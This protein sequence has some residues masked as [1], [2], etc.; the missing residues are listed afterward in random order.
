[1]KNIVIVGAGLSGSSM[2]RLLAEECGC[3]VIILEKRTHIAGNIYDEY[4]NGILVQKYGPHFIATFSWEVVEFLMKYTGF[5]EYPIRAKS[6]VNGKFIDRPYNFRT[7]QQLLDPENSA[8]VLE[9]IRKAFPN[10]HRVTL[11]EIV[12]NTD[13]VVSNYGKLLYN[14]LFVPYCAKQWGMKVEDISPDVINRTDIVLGYETQL[15][16]TDFQYLPEKGYTEMIKRMLDYPNIKV[17]LNVDA[18]EHL[19]FD[20]VNHKVLYN[21]SEDEII[22]YTGELDLLFHNCYGE[23]PY[24][25]RYFSYSTYE[26]SPVLPCGVITYPKEREY[27]RQTEFKQFNPSGEW[28]GSIVQSE[29]SLPMNRA[30]QKGNE[31]YYPVLNDKNMDQHNKYKQLAAKYSNLYYGGRLADFRYY[32]IDTAVLKVFDDFKKIKARIGK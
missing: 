15:D 30:A 23:L 18:R 20:D 26:E 1:M 6:F 24:R 5:Y 22:Y 16:D 31:P 17:Y 4:M 8:P 12:N 2:A 28:K 21:G 32:D 14:T 10:M 7:L 9:R 27:L 25:S 19:L 11:G 29:Y 13:D 3:H